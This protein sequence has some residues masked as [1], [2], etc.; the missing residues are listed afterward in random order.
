MSRSI[1]LTGGTVFVD[2]SLHP[3]DL[4]VRNGRIASLLLHDDE[5]NEFG[6]DL[7]VIDVG[8][9]VVLPGAIDTH[10]HAREPGHTHKEDFLSASRAAARGGVT[11]I[12]DMP[13]VEPPTDTV[14]TFLAKREMAAD[15]CIVDWGHW[16][17][18][19]KVSEIEA[20]ADAG[21]TG[22]KIFQVSG[23]YPHDPRLAM[24][25]E[26]SLLE[27]FREIANTGLPCLIHPFNQSLFDRLSREAL[28]RGLR[29]N[30]RTYSEI[31]TEESVW[32]TAVHTL[33][34][35]QE[36]S[37]VRLHLLHTHSGRSLR[38]IREAKALGLDVTAQIDPKYYHLRAKDLDGSGRSV[39]A[40]FVTEDDARMAEIWRSLQDG[41]IDVIGSDHAP[42]TLE[43]VKQ[44]EI[45]AWEANLGSPQLEWL[46]SLVLTDMADGHHSLADVVR[47]LSE[48]P[49]KLV[50]TW[51]QKGTLA[52][53]ADADLVVV[54]LNREF[55][56]SEN[57][58]ETRVGW[59]PYVGW[60][61]K[62]SIDMTMS[63]GEIVA[64]GGRVD[65][66]PGRGMYL[67]GRR[68]DAGTLP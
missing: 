60:P 14:E 24:N 42:H 19:T 6:D 28:E 67:R 33:I 2:G 18:G 11:T 10:T 43:E 25:D 59:S 38:L 40:G 51:P 32:A 61:M 5:H 49:A 4:I 55:I 66:I 58:V 12:V 17:A 53:G 27:V 62:G 45:D 47:L 56:V 16:V 31:Y 46:F 30:G 3:L 1:R 63:R 7:E 52:P 34:A 48:N 21:A 9:K 23:A 35:L 41:T 39:P 65:G 64:T 37:G 54:D 26:G 15:K 68:R 8:G 22:F 36:L 44:T 50:G 57:S 13:N 29:P 20:L